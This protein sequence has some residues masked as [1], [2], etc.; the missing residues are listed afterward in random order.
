MNIE[1]KGTIDVPTTHFTEV[2]LV[3]AAIIQ[4]HLSKN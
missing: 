3:P 1:E 2:C 4:K